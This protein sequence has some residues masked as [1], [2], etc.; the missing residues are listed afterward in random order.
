VALAAF[1]LCGG[2]PVLLFFGIIR[3]SHDMSIDGP[4]ALA[5]W[6]VGAVLGVV[7][8]LSKGPVVNVGRY[9]SCRELDASARCARAVVAACS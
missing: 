9:Q 4:L 7:S 3:P 6:G 2:S 1:G 5:L 8:L